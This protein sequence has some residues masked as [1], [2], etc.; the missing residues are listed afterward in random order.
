MASIAFWDMDDR[1]QQ[2]LTF[3]Q[4]MT[5]KNNRYIYI[6]SVF[7]TPHPDKSNQWAKWMFSGHFYWCILVFLHFWCEKTWNYGSKLT[8]SSNDSDDSWVQSWKWAKIH[9]HNKNDG[10]STELG[11]LTSWIKITHHRYSDWLK[12]LHNHSNTQTTISQSAWLSHTLNIV[13][14]A[15]RNVQKEWSHCSSRPA[16]WCVKNNVDKVD[17]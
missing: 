14:G 11:T 2:F 13:P 6:P 4:G 1:N 15:D 5:W 17:F 7:L 8:N 3:S 12:T 10:I 16:S 9:Q